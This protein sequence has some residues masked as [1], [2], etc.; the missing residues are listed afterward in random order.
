M[1]AI[2]SKTPGGLPG[3]CPV[4]G[5]AVFVVPSEAL[6]DAPCPACGVLLFPLQGLES[7]FFLI[8]DQL[9][10]VQRD[11]LARTSNR[12]R[13]EHLDSLDEVELVMEF[14]EMFDLRLPDEISESWKSIS[15]DDFLRW[16]LGRG[17]D[18][19]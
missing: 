9:S 2:S 7:S 15:I 11:W 17:P 16:W 14:D 12:M 10:R 19:F 13:N 5:V 18:K 4:C 1:G 8:A 3:K 6:S